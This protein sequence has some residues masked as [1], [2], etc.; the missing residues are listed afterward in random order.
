ML[1]NLYWAVELRDRSGRKDL[2]RGADGSV[3]ALLQVAGTDH[4]EIRRRCSLARDRFKTPTRDVVM[5][6]AIHKELTGYLV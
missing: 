3:M 2:E 6:L 1:P 5:F 4:F